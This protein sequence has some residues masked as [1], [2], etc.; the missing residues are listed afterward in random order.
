M[1]ESIEHLDDNYDLS[2]K[3]LKNLHVKF[4]KDP[5][6]FEQYDKVIQGQL[7]DNIIE[8]VTDIFKSENSKIHYLPHRAVLKQ[9]RSTTKLR[10]VFD[11]SASLPN[12]P[13]LMIYSIQVHP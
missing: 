6:F 3:R 4:Q 12:S 10:I 11:A 2:K 8:P 9:E 1:K 13:S 7:T 5:K